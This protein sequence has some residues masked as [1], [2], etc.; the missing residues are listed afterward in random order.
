M[1]VIC[2]DTPSGG[3][4]GYK[5]KKILLDLP[6]RRFK[7][8]ENWLIVKY[9]K[10]ALQGLFS[11]WFIELVLALHNL[12]YM[13]LQKNISLFRFREITSRSIFVLLYTHAITV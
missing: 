1:N 5:M 6:K 3:G 7:N 13:Y 4:G 11:V 8:K 10:T 9:F 2:P 12:I